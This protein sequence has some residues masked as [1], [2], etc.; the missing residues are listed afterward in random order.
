MLATES[1]TRSEKPWTKKYN[2]WRSSD[3]VH[4]RWRKQ[5]AAFLEVQSRAENPEEITEP[6]KKKFR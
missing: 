1:S 3:S 2:E 6:K 4:W 5:V